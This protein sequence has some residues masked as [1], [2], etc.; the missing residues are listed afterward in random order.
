MPCSATELVLG[1]AVILASGSFVLKEVYAA[2]AAHLARAPKSAYTSHSMA[3]Q[4]PDADI[5]R[6]WDDGISQEAQNLLEQYRKL[7]KDAQD[8]ALQALNLQRKYA[9]RNS[10]D[11]DHGRCSPVKRARTVD[12]AENTTDE[13]AS[14][15]E[16]RSIDLRENLST[17]ID[18][19]TEGV[20]DPR[21][22]GIEHQESN[23]DTQASDEEHIREPE[24]FAIHAL[25][26]P[27]DLVYSEE[28]KDK[29]VV[30]NQGRCKGIALMLSPELWGK[31]LAALDGNRNAF[32]QISQR[33]TNVEARTSR[34]QA[35]TE[36]H[37]SLETQYL[38]MKK[39]C[40]IQPRPKI[41]EA[42]LAIKDRQ[43]QLATLGEEFQAEDKQELEDT[44]QL[45][46]DQRQIDAE[47]AATLDDAFVAAGFR[48]DF[49]APNFEDYVPPFDDSI[50]ETM[51][52]ENVAESSPMAKFSPEVESDETPASE[53]QMESDSEVGE[54]D[55]PE[56]DAAYMTNPLQTDEQYGHQFTIV[57]EIG[58]VV[59]HPLNEWAPLMEDQKRL[60]ADVWK[61]YHEIQTAEDDLDDQRLRREELE[62]RDDGDDE[63][64]TADDGEELLAITNREEDVKQYIRFCE[65]RHDI[66]KY[67]A[68]WIGCPVDDRGALV[69]DED[70]DYFDG[71]EAKALDGGP[72]EIRIESF[73]D[74]VVPGFEDLIEEPELDEWDVGEE[75]APW[76]CPSEDYDPRYHDDL[77][78][79]YK[80]DCEMYW[81]DMETMAKVF[82]AP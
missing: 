55:A 49:Q 4:S 64:A 68:R 8:E 82:G 16:P 71:Q 19:E 53:E 26:D 47:L 41:I 76:D 21:E 2:H 3:A 66:A 17:S 5:D 36:C 29:F 62:G 37:R 24:S 63:E 48:E 57:P 18:V 54:H 14:M 13:D 20:A 6:L 52:F 44:D 33:Y 35:M 75:L 70:D 65:I 7:P 61:Y 46:I 43:E 22:E 27:D 59:P 58:M 72:H 80:Q 50:L 11:Q 12:I 77:D 45:Y 56:D 31:M 32:T 78:W 9:K 40:L 74:D 15:S 25:Q 51:H 10:E 28:Y 67:R 69:V 38:E 39:A 79:H 81:R 34:D 30:V 42:M 73:V 23:L 60:R 1:L